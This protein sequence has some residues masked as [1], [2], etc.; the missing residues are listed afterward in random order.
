M[1]HNARTNIVVPTIQEVMRFHP[2]VYHLMRVSKKADI[3]PLSEPIVAVN[4]D[5]IHEVPISKGQNVLVS[6]CAYNRYLHLSSYPLSWLIYKTLFSIKKI[7]G[8]D[9]DI[10]NPLR[11][12]EGKVEHEFKVGMYSNLLVNFT[13]LEPKQTLTSNCSVRMTFCEH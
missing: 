1:T 9:A 2:I 13:S 11:F 7:W 8:E 6:I 12:I 10:F 5:I 4:G 3:I